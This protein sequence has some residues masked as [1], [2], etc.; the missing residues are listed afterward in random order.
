MSPTGVWLIAGTPIARPHPCRCGQGGACGTRPVDFF[1]FWRADGGGCSCFG[2]R[3]VLRVAAELPSW[4]CGK[5]VTSL[6][7]AG[8]LS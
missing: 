1:D 7:L 2:R 5:T 4:C 3:D 6:R 8:L